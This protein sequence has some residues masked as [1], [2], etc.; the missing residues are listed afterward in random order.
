ML[1]RFIIV[2]LCLGIALC[3]SSI[4]FSQGKPKATEEKKVEDMTGDEAVKPGAAPGSAALYAKTFFDG[5][6]TYAN[7]KVQFKLNTRDNVLTDRIEYRLDDGAA[8]VYSAPFTISVEGKHSI[9]YYGTDKLGNKEDEKIFKVTIDNTPPEISVTT[10]KPLLRMGG[11]LFASKNTSFTVNAADALSRIEKTEYS[12]DPVK[13]YAEYVTPFNIVSD[14]EMELRVKSVDNVANAVEAFSLKILD[15]NNQEVELKEAAV[16]IFMDNI[17]PVVEIK[18]DKEFVLKE[19]KN[20]AAMDY[21]YAVNAAD[22]ESGIALVMVRTDGKGEFMPYKGEVTFS[23]NGE[24]IIEAKGVDKMGNQSNV[25]VLS[26]Y[27]DV[28]PPQ[29]IIETVSEK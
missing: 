26:V 11:K 1:K 25:S 12:S 3:L 7:S 4:T 15:E 19:G 2:V 22:N 8:Q 20:I 6:T 24:H 14:G 23:T 29:T 27:V 9:I 16:K 5:V 10:N 13:G 28:T 17:A 21:K 18:A